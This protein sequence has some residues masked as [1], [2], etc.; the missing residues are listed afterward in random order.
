MWVS[1]KKRSTDVALVNISLSLGSLVPSFDVAT[2]SSRKHQFM[3]RDSMHIGSARM[4]NMDPSLHSSYT[5]PRS[6]NKSFYNDLPSAQ[7]IFKNHKRSSSA[8]VITRTDSNDSDY[9]PLPTTGML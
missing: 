6:P 2:V 8:N 4:A 9:A 5:M 1:I 7:D 3:L